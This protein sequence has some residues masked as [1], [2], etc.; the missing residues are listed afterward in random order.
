MYR[1]NNTNDD[2]FAF[3]AGEVNKRPSQLPVR[4]DNLES[5]NLDYWSVEMPR[6]NELQDSYQMCRYSVNAVFQFFQN[7]IACET[8]NRFT[9]SSINNQ[10]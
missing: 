1:C 9:F 7:G 2:L 3:V 5:I 8:R 4:N 10:Q 6:Q